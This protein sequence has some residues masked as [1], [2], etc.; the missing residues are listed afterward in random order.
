MFKICTPDLRWELIPGVGNAPENIWDE[1]E[2]ESNDESSD[3]DEDSDTDSNLY[4]TE[5]AKKR[6]FAYCGERRRKRKTKK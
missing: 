5:K 4:E 1:I 3:S 2:S 6:R